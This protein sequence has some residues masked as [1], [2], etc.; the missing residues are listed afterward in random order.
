V[1]HVMSASL[2][3]HY[4]V[5]CAVSLQAVSDDFDDEGGSLCADSH[6]NPVQSTS[7]SASFFSAR[8]GDGDSCSLQDADDDGCL[9]VSMQVGAGEQGWLR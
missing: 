6:A 9:V 2:P 7:H 3:V 8:I 4:C 5:L 1:T